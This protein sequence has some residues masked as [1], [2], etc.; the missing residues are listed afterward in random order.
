[1][2]QLQSNN[3]KQEKEETNYGKNPVGKNTNK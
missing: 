3:P 1:M 2:L